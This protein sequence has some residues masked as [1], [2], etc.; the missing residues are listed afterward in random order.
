[1]HS[2]RGVSGLGSSLQA[3]AEASIRF[4][5][6]HAPLF[7]LADHAVVPRGPPIAL[8][9]RR[10]AH[11]ALRLRLRLLPLNRALGQQPLGALGG[12]LLAARQLGVLR[13]GG[14]AGDAG[15]A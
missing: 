15:D 14:V 11:L 13:R 8:R 7:L 9:R 1:M 4:E 3:L 2:L 5:G 10:V 6:Q 12:R